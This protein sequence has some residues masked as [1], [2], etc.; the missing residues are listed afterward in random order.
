MKLFTE[1][2]ARCFTMLWQAVVMGRQRGCLTLSF[3]CVVCD[4]QAVVM[5]CQRGWLTVSFMPVSDV[6]LLEHW[7]FIRLKER[8]VWWQGWCYLLLLWASVKE[9]SLWWVSW[10]ILGL[11]P[12]LFWLG[13]GFH[14]SD[15]WPGALMSFQSG[16]HQ[17]QDTEVI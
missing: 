1:L 4:W 15:L 14:D 16:S 8:S 9:R 12:H 5:G 3:T 11:L 13:L 10:F 2:L 6:T 17:C 7:P